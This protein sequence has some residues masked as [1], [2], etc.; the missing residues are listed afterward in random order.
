MKIIRPYL[1]VGGL[2]DTCDLRL[3]QDHDIGAMLTIAERV[4]YPG[5]ATV[6]LPIEDGEPLKARTI[7]KAVAFVRSQKEADR[8]TL[9]AC[10]FGVS[11][12]VTLA[13]AAIKEIEGVSLAQAFALVKAAHADAQ[14]HI[15]LWR[16]L[17][18][19]YG[20]NP[21]YLEAVMQAG[22]NAGE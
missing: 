11:R 4:A 3:L 12:S 1:A 5:I 10:A 19:R 21:S 18:E 14:P 20:E 16:S 22:N 13:T 6:F 8:V 9:V 7:D 15:V 2:R 17:C